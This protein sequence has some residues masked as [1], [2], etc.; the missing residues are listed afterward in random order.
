MR[1]SMAVPPPYLYLQPA[2][3]LTKYKSSSKVP[4]SIALVHS[5]VLYQHI[6]QYFTSTFLSTSLVHSLVLH[7]YIPQYFNATFPSTSVVHSLVFQC[8]FPEYFRSTLNSKFLMISLVHSQKCAVVLTFVFY[9]IVI[10]SLESQTLSMVAFNGSISPSLAPW[11]WGTYL[12]KH[13]E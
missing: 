8:Y 4:S 3:F 13:L 12:W 9:I 1:T 7:Q 5:L 11:E 2:G 10:V 6:P